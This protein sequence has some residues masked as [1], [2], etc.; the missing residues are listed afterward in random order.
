MKF[1]RKF[2]LIF[3]V[4]SILIGC[5]YNKN[6]VSTT[7][8]SNEEP[9]KELKSSINAKLI[10]DLGD[11]NVVDAKLENSNL[12][13]IFNNIYSGNIS[14][15]GHLC[16]ID[17]NNIKN[18][19]RSNI[20]YNPKRI[21]GIVDDTLFLHCSHDLLA[22]DKNSMLSKSFFVPGDPDV[23]EVNSERLYFMS[24]LPA[25]LSCAQ[26]TN[27]KIIWE[28][29][30]EEDNYELLPYVH[31]LYGKVFLIASELF[32]PTLD[33]VNYNIY[34]IV[35]DPN[36]GKELTRQPLSITSLPCEGLSFPDAFCSFKN[37][38]MVILS[39][40]K[41]DLYEITSYEINNSGLIK[42]LWK[43]EFKIP[44]SLFS[45][46]K[47]KKDIFIGLINS[48]KFVIDDSYIYI[49]YQESQR[50]PSQEITKKSLIALDRN[51]GKLIWKC[52]LQDPGRFEN[53][54][55]VYNSNE[56]GKILISTSDI[57]STN[58][59]PTFL[60][61]FYCIN[62]QNG[63]IIWQNRLNS[64]FNYSINNTDETLWFVGEDD[65]NES[66]IL[67]AINIK[68]G[69]TLGTFESKNKDIHNVYY[70]HNIIL[71]NGK[72]EAIYILGDGRIYDI[73]LTQKQ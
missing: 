3:I 63:N 34:L 6:S 30:I 66:I 46:N 42:K 31:E 56:K 37:N 23:L 4:C 36:S 62:Q 24:S 9:N 28:F 44:K 65:Q 27:P 53:F 21:V 15:W 22:F 32:Q 41:T 43:K 61:Y 67:N 17:L 39:K 8:P 40:R 16:L 52:N 45:P 25:V 51:S 70:D 48:S 13:L 2:V 72:D 1:K 55:K 50:E 5:N 69:T 71:P 35:L 68:E 49:P 19:K 26:R 38:Q 60:Y 64:F 7:Y 57:N 73:K 18:V 59:K 58:S 12:Y 14:S 11:V 47:D 20:I 33:T 10:F 29:K 54:I